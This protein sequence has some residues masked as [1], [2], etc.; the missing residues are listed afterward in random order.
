MKTTESPPFR[1]SKYEHIPTASSNIQDPQLDC[2]PMT[3]PSLI[4][5]RIC[6]LFWHRSSLFIKM[7]VPYSLLYVFALSYLFSRSR[8]ESK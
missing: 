6:H 2:T 7:N 5:N 1:V 4:E 3:N 8:A